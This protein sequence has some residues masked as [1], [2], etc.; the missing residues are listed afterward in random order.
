[1]I[2]MIS[3]VGSAFEGGTKKEEEPKAA[4]ELLSPIKIVRK[5][6]IPKQPQIQESKDEVF[7]ILSEPKMPKITP[8]KV[9]APVTQ[10]TSTLTGKLIRNTHCSD[11]VRASGTM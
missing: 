11:I 5:T 2:D 10:R 4:K 1:M 3:D 9:S 8:F 6:I 7:G